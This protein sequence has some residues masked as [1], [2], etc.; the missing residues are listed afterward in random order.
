[1]NE[2]KTETMT[3]YGYVVRADHK[4]RSFTNKAGKTV[5][6]E[7]PMYHFDI[8]VDHIANP[9]FPDDK[10]YTPAYLDGSSAGPYANFKSR[11]DIAAKFT[12]D[13]EMVTLDDIL[14][15]N[16]D[17]YAAPVAVIVAKSKGNL[18]PVGIYFIGVKYADLVP[19]SRFDGSMED[20]DNFS[21][22]APV[23]G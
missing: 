12:G 4:A 10:R 23:E 3:V 5:A 11:Y 13:G 14:E 20:F 6:E 2:K 22:P 18:Y 19:R 16:L 8:K 21:T 7:T 9:I 1:M 15:K 17:I